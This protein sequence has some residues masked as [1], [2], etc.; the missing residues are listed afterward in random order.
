ME[1]LDFLLVSLTRTD[2]DKLINLRFL[3][4]MISVYAVLLVY[5]LVVFFAAIFLVQGVKRV[6]QPFKTD[7]NIF[8]I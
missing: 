5:Y 6:S 8:L 1:S 7:M 4:V 3:S 2:Q